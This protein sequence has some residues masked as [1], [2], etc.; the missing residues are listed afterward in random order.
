MGLSKI[1]HAMILAIDKDTSEMHY[2]IIEYDEIIFDELVT[3]GEAILSYDYPPDRIHHSP[4]YYL[5]RMC[6]HIKECH[7][8]K[9]TTKAVPEKST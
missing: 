8:S 7:G 5:C 6:N 4:T 1:K 2:E 9:E 3:K